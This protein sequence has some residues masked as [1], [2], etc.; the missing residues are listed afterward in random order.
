MGRTKQLLPLHNGPVIAYCL[1]NIIASGIKD[2]VVVIDRNSPE[3]SEVLGRFPVKA[4]FNALSHTEM[5]DSV[6]T[7]LSH[8]QPS[9]SGVLVCLSDQPLVAELTFRNLMLLHRE[10]P[11]KILIPMFKG[12]KGHPTLFPFGTL[13]EI[14]PDLT[15]RQIISQD[16]DRIRYQDLPDEG[17]ILDMDTPGDYKTILQK[18]RTE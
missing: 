4:A 8:I 14:I 9:S 16:P 17:V 5:S 13:R 6:R 18:C 2:I 10:C 15:L 7:G 12:K 1:R 11:D 3:L